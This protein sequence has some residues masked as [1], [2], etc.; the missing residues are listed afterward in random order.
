[1]NS[2][3]IIKYSLIVALAVQLTTSCSDSDFLD[4]KP[5][6]T[7]TEGDIKAGGFEE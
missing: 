2:H 1:M 5:L 3:K 4:R 7:A 6:G